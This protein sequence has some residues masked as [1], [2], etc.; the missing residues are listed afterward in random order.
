M[1]PLDGEERSLAAG[2]NFPHKHVFNQK[3]THLAG[4]FGIQLY[5]LL[6]S[7]F[8]IWMS[9]AQ[10]CLRRKVLKSVQISF[11][12]FAV[13]SDSGMSVSAATLSACCFSS[14]CIILYLVSAIRLLGHV[15]ASS[16]HCNRWVCTT[17]EDVI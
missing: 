6:W 11:D 5:H 10:F 15:R 8:H 12:L 7:L 16:A 3:F 1:P 2:S 4:G 17:S 14:V 13:A 9:V